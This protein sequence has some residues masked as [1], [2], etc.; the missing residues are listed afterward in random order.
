MPVVSRTPFRGGRGGRTPPWTHVSRAAQGCLKVRFWH[1]SRVHGVQS[2]FPGVGLR[3]T[4]GYDLAPLQ[5]DQVSA[6]AI[7]KQP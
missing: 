4:P 3:A 2:A 5:G 1:P 7:F 6:D